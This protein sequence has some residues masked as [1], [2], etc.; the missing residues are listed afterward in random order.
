MQ[1]QSQQ[2]PQ[3]P[4]KQQNNYVQQ[5]QNVPNDNHK[6]GVSFLVPLNKIKASDYEVLFSRSSKQMQSSAK[7]ELR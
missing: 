3:M 4:P 7:I 2:P 5:P 1:Q 6:S